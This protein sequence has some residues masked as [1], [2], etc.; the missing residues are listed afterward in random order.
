MKIEQRIAAAFRMTDETWERHANPWSVWTRFTAFPALILA[1]WSRAWLGRWAVVPFGAA[2]LWT[3]LNPRLF[4][5]PASTDNW[6]SKAVLGERVWMNRDAVPLPPR[7]R[8]FPIVLNGLS[9]AALLVAI[10][11]LVRLS[12][13]PTFLGAA[14]AVA[15]KTWFLNEMVRL[16]GEMH[17]ATPEYRSWLY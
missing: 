3:W 2:T 8:T 14:L 13:W 10:W 17:E 7:Y 1:A 9:A 16:Y 12:A 11:G 15:L 6:A 5:K 4:E